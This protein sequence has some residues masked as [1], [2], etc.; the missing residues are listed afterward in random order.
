MDTAV[1]KGFCVK[2][3]AGFQLKAE[4]NEEDWDKMQMGEGSGL[5]SGQVGQNTTICIN[6]L[7]LKGSHCADQGGLALSEIHLPLLLRCWD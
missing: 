7:P 1:W 6:L 5:V 4:W 2:G 3:G